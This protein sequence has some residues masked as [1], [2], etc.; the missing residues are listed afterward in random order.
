MK[1]VLIVDDDDGFRE[2]LSALL[3]LEGYEVQEAA[4]GAEGLARMSKSPRPEVV[5]IDLMMPVMDGWE[6]VRAMK[7]DPELARIPSAVVSAARAPDSIPE[8]I[9]VF[10]KPFSVDALLDFIEGSKSVQ[11]SPK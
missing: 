10:A 7:K 4:N 9:P 3:S 11:G 1:K 8:T 6:L 5:L 2:S